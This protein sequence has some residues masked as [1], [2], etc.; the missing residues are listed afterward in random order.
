[1]HLR[2]ATSLIC[3]GALVLG[4]WVKAPSPGSREPK[5]D[6]QPLRYWTE[7]IIQQ[8]RAH[9]ELI[10]KIGTPLA[11]F[12]VEQL[13]ESGKGSPVRALY[14]AFYH[15]A[16]AALLRLLP[17]ALEDE[18]RC[19]NAIRALAYLGPDGG[20]AA[21]A[22]APFL[23][24]P[25]FAADAAHALASMGSAAEKAIPQLTAALEDQVP[26]AATALANAGPAAVEAIP[27]LERART[28][29][30][31]EGPGWFRR[32][33]ERALLRI[34]ESQYHAGTGGS[35]ERVEEH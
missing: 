23:S 27:A 29:A 34:S 1:M 22:V 24:D 9:R 15:H 26:W 14:I 17:E 31:A 11:P 7:L 4:A 10:R 3:L 6:G 8:P 35:I 21:T 18:Q 5:H 25:R 19:L 30:I 28:N 13:Q 20:A 16:P 2:I 32:E 33:V 12:L